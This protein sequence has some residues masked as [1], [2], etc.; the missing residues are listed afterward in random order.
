[1][2]KT[3]KFYMVKN[4]VSVDYLDSLEEVMNKMNKAKLSH[5]LV[6]DSEKNV[7]GVISK[8]D[9]LSSLKT[10]LDTT[11]GKIY[12]SLKK[13]SIT[14][15]E[16]MS[17]NPLYVKPTDSIDYAVELLLQKEFHC[18]PVVENGHPVGI[19]TFYDLLKAYYQH[20]G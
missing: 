6:T 18:L 1:M 2:P 12:S 14:A 15:K 20:Y 19:I 9:I 4:P 7:I 11:S 13:H 3:V 17:K 10:L 5:L 16:L 8:S